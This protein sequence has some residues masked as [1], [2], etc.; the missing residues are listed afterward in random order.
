MPLSF[1]SERNIEDD[2]LTQIEHFENITMVPVSWDMGEWIN[3]YN[4]I[5]YM[6]YYYGFSPAVVK[7]E[8]SSK[9]MEMLRYPE[10]GFIQVID[11]IVV[12][13]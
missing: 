2:T 12:V 7:I 5:A 1:S 9:I 6:A 13:K 10:D 11:N 4:Y 8:N 3:N